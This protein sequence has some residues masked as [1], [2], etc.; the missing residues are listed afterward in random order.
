MATVPV[1]DRLALTHPRTGVTVGL[2]PSSDPSY[3]LNLW[4][5]ASTS[6]TSQPASSAFSEL[7]TLGVINGGAPVAYVDQLSLT[8]TFWWYKVRSV[9]TNYA[10]PSA[11]TTAVTAQAGTLP[12]TTPGAIPFTGRPLQVAAVL[13]TQSAV[14]TFTAPN[15]SSTNPFNLLAGNYI[16][17]TI[18]VGP[19][20][21]I[22]ASTATRAFAFS[23]DGFGFLTL[24]PTSTVKQV[25]VAAVPVPTGAQ[26]TQF[27]VTLSRQGAN[28]TATVEVF[29]SGGVL[30]SARGHLCT[31]TATAGANHRGYFTGARTT[32]GTFPIFG[33]SSLGA[34]RNDIPVYMYIRVTLKTTAPAAGNPS[35]FHM[36][37]VPLARPDLKSFY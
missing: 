22:P 36:M 15:I 8:K 32:G 28:S 16:T 30:S 6:A 34:V 4:R 37:Y 27:D 1:Q 17:R 25:F 7:A 33:Y 10:T 18:A 23:T 35:G 19:A 2:Y 5:A 9:R 29:L 21:C 31:M 26:P 14:P 11:F 24:K 20:A 12:T 3:D 13:Q